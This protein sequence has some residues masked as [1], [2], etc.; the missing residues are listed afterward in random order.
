MTTQVLWMEGFDTRHPNVQIFDATGG[1]VVNDEAPEAG[2]ELRLSSGASARWSLPPTSGSFWFGQ[3]MRRVSGQPGL[4]SHVQ[5]AM[6][7]LL[8]GNTTNTALTLLYRRNGSVDDWQIEIRIGEDIGSAPAQDYLGEFWRTAGNVIPPGGADVTVEITRGATDGGFRLIVDNV[9]LL[10]EEGIAELADSEGDLTGM[11][12]TAGSSTSSSMIQAF[13]D[14]WVADGNLG[15]A[16]IVAIIPNAVGFYSQG[17]PSGT[18]DNYEQ[19]NDVPPSDAEHVTFGAGDKDTYGWDTSAL[20]AVNA[21]RC[22]AVMLQPRFEGTSTVKCI[23]RIDGTDH[24]L[25]EV[26]NAAFETGRLI[27]PG[28]PDTLDLW[29]AADIAAAEFGLEA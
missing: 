11:S 10:A 16:R 28:N 23:A 17:T 2:R 25:G 18:G 29:T 20:T 3:R 7:I 9:Q 4:N 26:T 19:L 5:R 12:Y 15:S 1:T 22:A 14:Q 21:L 8:G 13:D 24:T 6:A 27:V